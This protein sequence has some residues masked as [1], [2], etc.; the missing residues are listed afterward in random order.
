MYFSSPYFD[1]LTDLFPQ[2]SLESGNWLCASTGV[3]NISSEFKEMGLIPFI[4]WFWRRK[5]TTRPLPSFDTVTHMLHF[6]GATHGSLTLH[7]HLQEFS[8]IL[9]SR[10]ILLVPLFQPGSQFEDF[11]HD[12]LAVVKQIAFEDVGSSHILHKVLMATW[13]GLLGR[14]TQMTD[15]TWW[16]PQT[17]P[18][19]NISAEEGKV[20]LASQ[21]CLELPLRTYRTHHLC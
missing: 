13:A 17:L 5:K 12:Y 21:A 10:K 20:V 8:K 2:K 16:L 4:S 1:N 7:P 11:Q 3:A 6:Q 19:D 15:V 18:G 14:V 9:M